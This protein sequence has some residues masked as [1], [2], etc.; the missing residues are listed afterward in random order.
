VTTPVQRLQDFID[1]APT[2]WQAAEEIEKRLKAASFQPLSELHPWKLQKASR[3]YVRRQGAI[4]AFLVPEKKSESALVFATHTD[5]PTLKLKPHPLMKKEGMTFL[6]FEVY[7]SPMLSSWQGK[8]LYL[9]GSALIEKEGALQLVGVALDDTLLLIPQLPIHL[10]REA[11]EKQATLNRQEH[12]KALLSIEASCE[13]P[14]EFLI[15][16][17]IG[18][19]KVISYDLYACAKEKSSLIGEKRE[20]ISS[21]RIDNLFSAS[22]CLAALEDYKEASSTTL[23]MAVFYDHEEIGSRTKEGAYSPFFDDVLTRISLSLEISN[24]QTLIIKNRSLCLSIDMAHAFNP[25]FENKYEPGH[26]ALLGEGVCIKYNADHKYATSAFTSGWLIHRCSALQIPLQPFIAR[27]DIG[28][29]S[30]VGPIFSHK[31]GI[32]TVDIGAAQLSM[33]SC[34]EVASVKDYLDLIRLIKGCMDVEL[35]LPTTC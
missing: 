31:T 12:I 13:N 34:R 2:S 29:G 11:Q 21:S 26:K 8:D 9:A 14:I 32:A 25:L 33:H 24:E 7:G 16:K 17:K 10:D 1:A 27:S 5:S 22:A 15:Q 18:P 20:L 28:C 23:Q 30:T 6:T 3:Y 19:C 4:I 35:T